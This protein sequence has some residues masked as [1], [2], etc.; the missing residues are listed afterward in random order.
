[1]RLWIWTL[2]NC[3]Y[4]SGSLLMSKEWRNFEHKVVTGGSTCD[5]ALN[6]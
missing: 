5:G 4:L 3:S 1:V 2:N 6:I